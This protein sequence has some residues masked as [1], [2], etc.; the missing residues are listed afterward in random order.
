MTD[1]PKELR[2]EPL[3][4][5]V[6]EVR[7][8]GSAS[9]ADIIP[10]FLFHALDPKP[11]ITRLP[12]ADIPFPLRGADPNLQYTPTIRLEWGQFFVAVGDRNIVISCKLPGYPKWPNFKKAILETMKLI[13]TVGI[14]GRVERYSVKY[15]NLIQGNTL[16]DQTNKIKMA[17]QLGPDEITE[18]QVSL[19]VHQNEEAIL[20]ILSIVIGAEGQ[21]GEGPRIRGAIVD[22]D[23]IRE[24]TPIDFSTFVK[25]FEPD[26]EELRQ[27]NKVKFFG[28]L[29]SAAIKE[30]EPVHD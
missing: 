17:I 27:S 29:T 5:A 22:I 25:G 1:L 13:E 2:K 19:Q 10:G 16:R 8:S 24:V 9:L 4:D 7:L 23:S 12:A 28:C 6:F 18:N 21:I 30:M 11:T 3:V 20:H 26:L 14:E 15:V